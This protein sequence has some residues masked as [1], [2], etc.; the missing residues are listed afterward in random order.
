MPNHSP[1]Q[2]NLQTP[3]TPGSSPLPF[4][5]CSNVKFSV[6][7][8]WTF[9]S[10]RETLPPV[11][12][13]PHF[14]ALCFPCALTSYNLLYFLL[15]Y[16]FISAF[17]FSHQ[18]VISMMARTFFFFNLLLYSNCLEQSGIENALSHSQ[19]CSMNES[20]QKIKA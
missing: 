10:K 12:P 20:L 16:F 15:F 4:S 18:N 1:H 2:W 13:Y 3:G 5:L 17:V 19:I 8:S 14:P 9:L 6:K 7:T 11:L